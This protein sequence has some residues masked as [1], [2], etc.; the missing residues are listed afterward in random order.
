MWI[1]NVIIALWLL[2]LNAWVHFILC[3][4][5]SRGKNHDS[6]I[7]LKSI[8]FLIRFLLKKIF[9]FITISMNY[10]LVCSLLIISTGISGLECRLSTIISSN[11][12][13]L[14]SWVISLHC[15]VRNFRNNS[16]IWIKKIWQQQHI[17]LSLFFTI[18]LYIYI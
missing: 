18:F 13:Y 14:V 2:S 6:S 7:K 17:Q 5:V 10:W 4:Q 16:I 9:S 8:P 15:L 3:F 11:L 1:S 12:T